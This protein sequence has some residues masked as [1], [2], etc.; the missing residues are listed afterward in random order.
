VPWDDVERYAKQNKIVVE[1]EPD[2][3]AKFEVP[4]PVK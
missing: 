4:L 2:E 3:Y 1:Y